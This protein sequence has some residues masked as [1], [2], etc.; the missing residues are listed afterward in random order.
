MRYRR[1][2]VTRRGGPEVLRVI[3]DDLPEPAAGQVRVKVLA[4]GVAFGD[5][6]R[7]ALLFDAGGK[8]RT[9]GYDIVGRVDQPGEGVTTVYPGQRVAA[10]PVEGG[11]AEYL[12]LPVAELIPVPDHLDPAEAVCMTL[13][14]LTAYQLLHRLADVKEGQRILIHAAAGGVGTALLQLGR[15]AGVEMYGTASAGKHQ[16]VRDF[17]ATPID[18]H[19]EDVA[20]RMR[21]LGGVDVVFDGVG[22]ARHLWGSYQ[23]L[24]AGGQLI[25]YGFSSAAGHGK[26]HLLPIIGSAALLAALWPLPGKSIKMYSVTGMKNHHPEWYR[27]DVTTLFDLLAQRKIRPVISQRLPLEQAA[28]AHVLLEGAAEIG[29]IVLVMQ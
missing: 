5:V 7:R 15:L 27:E 23:A 14:Y 1:V 25:C 3:E 8:P 13:N 12:N 22:G 6:M 24:R 19:K 9:L 18:Y 10:M 28:L 4:A 20:A 11:Y 17:G 21:E 26:T 16:I 2:A 29:K